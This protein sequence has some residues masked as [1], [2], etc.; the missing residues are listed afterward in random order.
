MEYSIR[1]PEEMKRGNLRSAPAAD[2]QGK[3]KVSGIVRRE[4]ALFSSG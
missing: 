2:C 1:V 4:K 3:P